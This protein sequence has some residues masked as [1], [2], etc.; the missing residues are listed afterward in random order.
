ME[1]VVLVLRKK[2]PL[3]A[4]KP[5]TRPPINP[6]ISISRNELGPMPSNSPILADNMPSFSISIQKESP[7]HNN[8][9]PQNAAKNESPAFCITSSP[10]RKAA[11]AM[12]HHGRYSPAIKDSNAVNMSAAKNFICL[13]F[14]V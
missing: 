14:I 11:I 7:L 10:T 13:F 12:P 4:A 8:K 2:V 1:R 5:A 3:I 6:V 9:T